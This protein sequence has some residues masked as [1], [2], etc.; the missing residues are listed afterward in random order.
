MQQRPVS[1]SFGSRWSIFDTIA[2][3]CFGVSCAK[4]WVNTAMD[5]EQTARDASAAVRLPA[6]KFRRKLKVFSRYFYSG[7]LDVGNVHQ[8]ACTRTAAAKYLIPKLEERCLAFVNGCMKLDDVCPFLDYVLTMGEEGARAPARAL[9]RKNSFGVI[10]SARFKS[11]T[12]HTV[13]YVLRHAT[14]VSESSVLQAVHSWALQQWLTPSSEGDELADVRV[15]VRAIMLPLFSELRFLALT[16]TEFVEGPNTWGILTDS[17]ARAIL[18]NIV[19]ERSMTMPDGFC[20][21]R[22]ART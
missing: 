13:R 10:S 14:N 18:S 22:T 8:A 6:S 7:R 9:I 1:D 12:L 11:S 3:T 17:E 20:K 15:N 2:A 19:K 4:E 16:A 5:V 21:I